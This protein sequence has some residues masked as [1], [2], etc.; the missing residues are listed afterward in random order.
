MSQIEQVSLSLKSRDFLRSSEQPAVSSWITPTHFYLTFFNF[1]NVKI[2]RP[3]LKRHLFFLTW[4]SSELKRDNVTETHSYVLLTGNICNA[5][6]V[7]SSL[8]CKPPHLSP[9][10][11]Q[12]EQLINTTEQKRS[13]YLFVVLFCNLSK[14]PYGFL[15]WV[16]KLNG[17]LFEGMQLLLNVLVLYHQT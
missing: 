2:W 3:T 4:K 7:V 1:S 15:R 9:T 10:P 6:K 16:T 11:S 17:H 14:A 8:C 5:E 12:W 13:I